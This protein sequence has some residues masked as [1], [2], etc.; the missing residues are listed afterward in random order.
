MF[1]K[2]N[3]LSES[4]QVI[5]VRTSFLVSASGI[6]WIVTSPPVAMPSVLAI[7]PL[8]MGFSNLQ[9]LQPSPGTH[10]MSMP[11]CCRGGCSWWRGR[12]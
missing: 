2:L 8:T 10:T 4:S 11:C 6:D 5:L 3:A 12:V 9:Q 7:S 1:E